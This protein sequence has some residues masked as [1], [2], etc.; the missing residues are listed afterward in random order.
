LNEAAFVALEQYPVMK[1]TVFSPLMNDKVRYEE[2]TTVP[3]ES[4]AYSSC[5]INNEIIDTA[6]WKDTTYKSYAPL[7]DSIHQS[8]PL[9]PN[10]TETAIYK[11]TQNHLEL[12][13][14]HSAYKY[15]VIGS[16]SQISN[17]MNAI[18]E[19]RVQGDSK[20]YFMENKFNH[21]VITSK[22]AIQD[23]Y[24]PSN[25]L[26]SDITDSN[27]QTFLSFTSIENKMIGVLDVQGRKHVFF[28][29]DNNIF[30]KNEPQ[31]Q[32]Q[33]R[34]VAFIPYSESKAYIGLEIDSR[35]FGIKVNILG[36]AF[37]AEWPFKN[38]ENNFGQI[39]DDLCQSKNTEYHDGYCVN[40]FEFDNTNDDF[41]LLMKNK[42]KQ[43]KVVSV[44]NNFSGDKE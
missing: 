38:I 16:T 2:E 33:F 17:E 32:G 5:I 29:I 10:W 11:T 26:Q 42:K 35:S 12:Y 22:P 14:P 31:R 21:Q 24:T 28:A 6:G 4:N 37:S 43:N 34:G 25:I 8:R 19:F 3:H 27:V 9:L 36:T 44:E 15:F 41:D 13:N 20:P 7:C 39:C 18:L 1:A 40:K 30:S 23:L